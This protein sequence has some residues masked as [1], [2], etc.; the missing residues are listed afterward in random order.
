MTAS[1]SGSSTAACH[2]TLL[3]G[4]VTEEWL[5]TLGVRPVLGAGISAGGISAR[6]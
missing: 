4:I 2:T 5:S 3:G 6:A 1:V